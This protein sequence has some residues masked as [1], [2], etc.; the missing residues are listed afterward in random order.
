MK[1]NSKLTDHCLDSYCKKFY[2][3]LT[4]I[5]FISPNPCLDRITSDNICVFHD[6]ISFKNLYEQ[7]WSQISMSSKRVL[8]EPWPP[9]VVYYFKHVDIACRLGG[10]KGG[11]DAT[12]PVFGVCEKQRRRPASTFAPLFLV[13]YEYHI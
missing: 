12:N 9:Y 5:L 3:S 8:L 11:L 2:K 1:F 4:N 7:R 6:W 10:H 13:Y